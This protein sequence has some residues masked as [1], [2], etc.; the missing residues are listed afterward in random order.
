MFRLLILLLVFILTII[1]SL[2]V[3]MTFSLSEWKLF[4]NYACKRWK[5][6]FWIDD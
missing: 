5:M 4:W 2:L 6:L 3:L 1:P